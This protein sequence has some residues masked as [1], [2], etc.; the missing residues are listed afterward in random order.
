[1]KEVRYLISYLPLSYQL[2]SMIIARGPESRDCKQ[3]MLSRKHV[4]QND[5]TIPIVLERI[6]TRALAN[7]VC[8]ESIWVALRW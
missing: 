7:D 3:N 6:M 4:R 8:A 2:V 1:M 5:I